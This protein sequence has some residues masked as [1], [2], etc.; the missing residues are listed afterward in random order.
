MKHN[1]DGEICIYCN[2]A[3]AESKDHT[4]ARNFFLVEHRDNLPR[5]L[6]CKRCNNKKSQLEKYLMIVLAFGAKHPDAKRNLDELVRPRLENE[7]NSKLYRRLKRDY[8]RSG[9]MSVSFNH[10]PF[11]QLSSMIAKALAFQHFNVRLGEGFSSTAAIFMDQATAPFEYMLSLGNRVSGDLGEG[12]FKYRGSQP[13]KYPEQTLWRFEIYGGID[14]AGSN[15]PGGSASL[16]MAATGN[17]EFI[18]D[19]FYG[20]QMTDREVRKTAGRNDPCPCG[21]G[22]KHKKC[23]GSVEKQVA[24]AHMQAQAGAD[25]FPQSARWPLAAHGYLPDQAAEMR[26]YFDDVF[27]R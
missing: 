9:G 18:G 10:R 8:E 11:I 25:Q 4:V 1:F 24:R 26:R 19:L 6:A 16:T 14:F 27:N 17:K 2:E 15:M 23:H 13:G 21:S 12:T 20:T 5:V 7:W 3:P 22:L